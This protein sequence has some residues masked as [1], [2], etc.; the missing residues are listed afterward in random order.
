[1]KHRALAVPFVWPNLLLPLA[2]ALV[3][4][5]GTRAQGSVRIYERA[6]SPGTGW[7][8]V[9]GY[10][11]TLNHLHVV[12][13]PNHLREWNGAGVARQPE[14]VTPIGP[15]ALCEYPSPRGPG[16]GMLWSPALGTW[17]MSGTFLG[18]IANPGVPVAA[19]AG[20]ARRQLAWDHA[21]DKAV[22]IVETTSPPS[23]TAWQ[24][25]TNHWVWDGLWQSMPLPPGNDR[26]GGMAFD[27]V[28]GGIVALTDAGAFLWDDV[29]WTAV[30]APA[31]Y[32]PGRALAFDAARQRLVAF[33]G[34][35][36][37]GVSA[38]TIE[39][40]GTQWTTVTP[41]VSPP[42][43]T[44][45][46]LIW[47]P[48]RQQ[49][50]LFGGYSASGSVIDD[51]RGFDGTTWIDHS[52]P[53]VRPP[54]LTEA[55]AADIAQGTF[56]FGGLDA[57]GAATNQTW[58]WDGTQWAN[59]TGSGPSPSPRSAAAMTA[60]DPNTILLFGGR[61]AN[62]TALNDTWLYTAAGGWT[63]HAA[64]GPYAGRYDAA[65]CSD[66][67]GTAW[68][69]GGNNGGTVL[70]DLLRFSFSQGP[71]WWWNLPAGSGL[72]PREKC[73]LV[74][75]R[76]TARLVLFGGR[77]ALNPTLGATMAY[78]TTS[79]FSV[80]YVPPIATEPAVLDH[81]MVWDPVKERT[82]IVGG[83]DATSGFF[84][85]AAQDWDGG[86]VWQA[87]R[88]SSHL[89][90]V[91][92]ASCWRESAGRVFLFG[93][94]TSLTGAPL[95]RTLELEHPFGEARL[96]GGGYGAYLELTASPVVTA[97][98]MGVLAAEV[99]PSS[100][101]SGGIA[102]LFVDFQMVPQP[103]LQLPTPLFC[104]NAEWTIQNTG[105]VAVLG[106]GDPVPFALP[107]LPMTAGLRLVL[108]ALTFEA[109][110]C[111]EATQPVF[112]RVRML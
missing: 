5:T 55:C 8:G 54:A 61:A 63:L 22:L 76:R 52:Q 42:A 101:P 89:R 71:F 36:G 108:Q 98:Q 49:C 11:D 103:F 39:W 7:V 58:R 72:G 81:A 102:G 9:G 86:T 109:S 70:G 48:V 77:N 105:A 26:F 97:Q 106:F 47:D 10:Y 45:A 20:V 107:L 53:T 73:G 33:G 12:I 40:D 93:G 96:V 62:G 69:F 82:V 100:S 41:V 57:T 43:R 44:G 60:L 68:L 19:S 16:Y 35:S 91:G 104:S 78:F 32:Q 18:S 111:F 1:M 94:Q 66:G 112:V 74:Y 67:A 21:H 95:D 65:L 3:V 56:V 75:E 83:Y 2:L 34:G 24:L 4:S 25:D 6:V 15:G 87:S 51:I 28:R 17:T 79:P 31:T 88:Y 84:H 37:A 38:Q 50:V 80:W 64:S 14:P 92:A 59:V 23:S 46:S 27:P 85:E 90:F 13:G 30:P 99:W 29:A 110:G